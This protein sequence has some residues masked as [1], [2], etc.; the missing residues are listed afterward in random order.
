MTK[1]DSKGTKK[2]AVQYAPAP[3]AEGNK[4]TAAPQVAIVKENKDPLSLGR[5]RI[6]YPWQ[7][8]DES[9]ASP[10]I[11]V[12]QP[13]ASAAS[14]IR[15]TPQ[16]GDEVMVGY[17]F[18]DVERPFMMGAIASTVTN[19]SKVNGNDSIIKSLNGQQIKF[20]NPKNPAGFDWFSPCIE[21]V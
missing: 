9:Q 5:V 3:L 8:D 16:V 21:V 18:D 20:S 1:K 6:L 4:R 15:F 12:A 7:P 19:G 17:E 14:G 10:F 11:R 13:Y 2:Y